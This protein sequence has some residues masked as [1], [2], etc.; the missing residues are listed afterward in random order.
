TGSS[1]IAARGNESLPHRLWV[2][3]VRGAELAV[4]DGG[5]LAGL[6]LAAAAPEDV[7]IAHRDAGDGNQVLVDRALV[8]EDEVFV[9]AVGDAHDVDVAEF[10]TGLAPVGVSHDVEPSDLPA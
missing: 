1:S 3:A 4:G 7:G 8:G 9:G 6:D 10:F 5:D 2:Q